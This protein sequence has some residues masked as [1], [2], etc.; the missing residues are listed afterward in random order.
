M[1]RLIVISVIH[2]AADLGSLAESVRASHVERFG[3][4]GWERRQR[5]VEE[6]WKDTRRAV[7]ALGLDF[8]LVRVYQDGLPVCGQEDRIVREAGG[9]G[10]PEPP[11]APGI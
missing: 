5:A 8:R 7:D 4:E 6:L 1:K 10:Q 3:P 2:T 9:G 11:V